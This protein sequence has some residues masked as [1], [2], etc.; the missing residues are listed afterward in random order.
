MKKLIGLLALLV[1][2]GCGTSVSGVPH[3]SV[4]TNT[5]AVAIP[6]FID[7]P[8]HIS[9]PVINVESDLIETDLNKDGTIEVPPIDQ[10]KQ[11]SW[12]GR[13]AKP[14]ESGRPAVILGHVDGRG[15]E[16]I[17]YDLK[18]IKNGDEIHIDDKL[19]I[20]YDKLK[21]SKQTFPTN[22]VYGNTE[23]PEIRLITCGGVF[24]QKSGHYT[25]N[26]VV[27]ARITQMESRQ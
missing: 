8:L 7:E 4:E 3:S 17:F 15:Q 20:V 9:I 5:P 6:Q 27:F 12:Y 23:E 10:P 24:D 18:N 16:G 1:L 21:V 25:D 14:G 13:F 19:F 2:V 11:A 22:H 26:W